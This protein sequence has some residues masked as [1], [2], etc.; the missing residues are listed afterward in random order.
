MK[1]DPK[2]DLTSN[3]MKE[4]LR[5]PLR[6]TIIAALLPTLMMMTKPRTDGP[7]CDGGKTDERREKSLLRADNRAVRFIYSIVFYPKLFFRIIYLHFFPLWKAVLF[8]FKPFI[9]SKD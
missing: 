2:R 3:D 7:S 6:T 1:A 4:C 8:K 9:G 5:L